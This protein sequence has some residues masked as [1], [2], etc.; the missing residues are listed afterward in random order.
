MREYESLVNEYANKSYARRTATDRVGEEGLRKFLGQYRE[1]RFENSQVL[2]FEGLKGRL[3]SSS[4][5]P[6]AG[7]ER[8]ESILAQLRKLFNSYQVNDVVQFDYETEVYYAQLS[9]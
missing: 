8:Y 3:L 1:K 5:A 9:S 2:E 4:Y 7:E 6:L